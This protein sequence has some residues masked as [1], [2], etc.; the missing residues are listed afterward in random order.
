MIIPTIELEVF[1]SKKKQKITA[2]ID[3]GFSGYLC[4]PVD[5]A[6]ELGLELTGTQE[7]QLADGR[8]VNQLEFTGQVVFLG[9][10]QTVKISLTDSE[11]AQ[12][13]TMLLGD[14][15]LTIDFPANKTQLKRKPL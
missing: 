9:Q 13:G 1:G 15:R 7:V 4:I 10:A 11:M 8:W 6:R 3:T 14:C 12:V 2:L 5:I